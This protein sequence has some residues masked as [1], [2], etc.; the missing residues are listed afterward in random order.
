MHD[1]IGTIVSEEEVATDLGFKDVFEMRRWSTEIGTRLTELES[2]NREMRQDVDR[3]KW[4]GERMIVVFDKVKVILDSL[5]DEQNMHVKKDIDKL[6]LAIEVV[7]GRG[8]DW[9]HELDNWLRK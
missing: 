2:K 9:E 1:M 5:R 3:F 8:V 4:H 6:L 7:C